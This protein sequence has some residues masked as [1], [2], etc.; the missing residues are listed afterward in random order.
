VSWEIR[1]GDALEQLREMPDESVQCCVTSPPFYGLTE[2]LD[3]CCN[4]AIAK[5]GLGLT[6]FTSNG[7]ST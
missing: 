7:A 6:Y 2:D 5:S 1:Q 4:E 3:H